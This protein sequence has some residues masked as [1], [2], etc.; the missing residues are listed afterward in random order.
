MRFALA[1]I[2][3]LV[4][5]GVA[6]GQ[7]EG[8][9]EQI[10]FDGAYRPN[11][12]T[13][14]R[15]KLRA[16]TNEPQSLRLV[17]VQEDLDKDPVNFWLPITL[18]PNIDGSA[19]DAQYRWMYF[20]PF[21]GQPGT[22]GPGGFGLNRDEMGRNLRV[23][24]AT[25][26][27]KR[28][29]QLSVDRLNPTLIDGG[30]GPGSERGTRLVLVVRGEN[31]LSSPAHLHAVFGAGP[32]GI[33]ESMRFVFIDQGALPDRAIG[34]QSVDAVLWLN[35]DPA[36]LSEP[37]MNALG[38]WV[39]EGGRMVVCQN[40]EKVATVASGKF[41]QLVPVTF[42]ETDPVR[43]LNFAQGLDTLRAIA[44][45]HLGQFPRYKREVAGVDPWWGLR[46]NK[47]PFVR[48]TIKRGASVEVWAD[49]EHRT[50]YLVR[51]AVGAGSV[52]WVAQDLGDPAFSRAKPTTNPSMIERDETWWGWA[53]I[54]DR[55]FDFRQRTLP[56]GLQGREAFGTE[57]RGLEDARRSV[58]VSTAIARGMEL[59]T[60][61]AAL[62]GLAVLFFVGYWVLAGPGSYILLSKRKM[63]TWSWVGFAACAVGAT[64]LT[65]AVVKVVLRG[66]PQ[67]QHV[68]FVRIAPGVEGLLHI[69]E[70]GRDFKAEEG[71]EV[72]VVVKKMDRQ[73]KK[74]GLVQAPDD[75]QVGTTVQ[76]TS[77]QLKVNAVVTGTVERIE[78]YGIF[79]Q[80]DGTKGRSG[81]GL[82]PAA[83]LGVPRG[84]DLRKSFPEGTKLTCKVLEIGEGK[85]RLSVKGAK[86][87]EER[88]DYEAARGKANVPASLGTFADLLKGRKL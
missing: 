57:W 54:W 62:V 59:P 86:D 10:G 76:Q 27:G 36:R 41:G 37:A 67:L 21:I 69:S 49:E 11:C 35:E 4:S 66:A 72:R 22:A 2:L 30:F 63:G 5:C 68:S 81:R 84:T 79:V 82:V 85:L 71:E 1:G 9:V 44:E 60:R 38:E 58:D 17:V 83:E 88:A 80:V 34:Y 6:L 78:T 77:T 20:I 3:L 15:V 50:P 16:T 12:W 28:I 56:P 14:L 26:K 23:Y 53:P 40:R 48:A 74:I 65:V 51:W 42:P 13:P 46:D 25:E 47:F 19:N 70:L 43:T 55:V 39:R 61:G 31:A 29:A 75:A 64:A 45:P 32:R 7:A 33:M 8:A 73:A 18:S 24:V 87:A 52:G